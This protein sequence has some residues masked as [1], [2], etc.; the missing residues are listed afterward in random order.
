MIEPSSSPF[1][2]SM[3]QLRCSGSK[4][5]RDGTAAVNQCINFFA[6][7]NSSLNHSN[8]QNNSFIETLP[9]PSY[10]LLPVCTYEYKSN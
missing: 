7:G 10:N 3:N 9:T 2:K 1:R 6:G 4:S 5:Q 8:N